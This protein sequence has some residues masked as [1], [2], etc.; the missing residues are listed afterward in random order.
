MPR[1]NPLVHFQQKRHSKHVEQN[2]LYGRAPSDKLNHCPHVCSAHDELQGAE[3]HS[4]SSSHHEHQTVQEPGLYE[5]RLNR[6]GEDAG[7]C[8]S[9]PNQR[10]GKSISFVNEL[11]EQQIVARNLQCKET[12]RL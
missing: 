12:E 9:L 7:Y 1:R 3:K 8:D 2:L 11:L 5:Y 4:W 6:H 10:H